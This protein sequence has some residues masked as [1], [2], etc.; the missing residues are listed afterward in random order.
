[1]IAVAASDSSVRTFPSQQARLFLVALPLWIHGNQITVGCKELAG[2]FKSRHVFTQ[3]VVSCAQVLSLCALGTITLA[4]GKN[5]SLFLISGCQSHHTCGLWMTLVCR[6]MKEEQ[7]VL[8]GSGNPHP[9]VTTRPVLLAMPS[10]LCFSE[11]SPA[12][13]VSFPSPGVSPESHHWEH[14][15]YSL[16]SIKSV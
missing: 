11:T 7:K 12:S 16:Y 5:H 4:T 14:S 15:L 6:V 3:T 10:C 2:H 8:W 1:M 9:Q 13:G